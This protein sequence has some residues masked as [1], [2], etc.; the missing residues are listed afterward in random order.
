[1][2]DDGAG[3]RKGQYKIEY[4]STGRAMCKGPKPCKGSKLEKGVLRVGVVSDFQGHV[5]WSYRHYG[6]TTPKV[7][8]NMKQAYSS[9]EDVEGFDTLTADD[10][11]KFKTA[12]EKGHVEA[13]DVP[14]TA[15]AGAED[16]EELAP[17]KKKPGRPRK[18]QKT[19]DDDEDDRPKPKKKA[20]PRRKKKADSDE[21]AELS[22]SDDA[23]SDYG[24]GKKRKRGGKKSP[25]KK[26]ADDD[27][28]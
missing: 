21:D 22:P 12:W 28:Y 9:A 27:D 11:Q 10:Q 25:K 16:E 24:S 26:G 8:T 2:S 23:G 3:P 19:D 18:K 20:A 1:M 13:D 6:C 15:V 14:A 4:S 17:S 7:F 5:S